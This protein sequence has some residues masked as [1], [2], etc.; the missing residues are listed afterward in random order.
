[1]DLA[2][3]SLPRELNAQKAD[4]DGTGTEKKGRE[5]RKDEL[6]IQ[7]RANGG[8][9]IHGQRTAHARLQATVTETRKGEGRANSQTKEHKE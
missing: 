5:E 7:P 8:Y 6:V 9:D 3:L 4:N 1:M 2:K